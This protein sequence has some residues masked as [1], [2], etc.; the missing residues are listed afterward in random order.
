VARVHPTAV[1][2]PR[3]KLANDVEVGPYA[4]IEEGVELASGVVIGAHATLLGRTS[5]GSRTRIH[6]ASV[7]GG[8]PQ[9]RGFEGG[10][11]ALGIGEDNVIREF[12]VIH[13]GSQDGSG[14]TRIGDGN[15]IMNHVHVAHDCRIGSHCVL[16]SYSALAGHAVVEDHAVTGAFTGVHQYTRIGESAFTAANT[17]VSKGVPPFA[18]VAGD[19]ARLVGL[20]TLGLQRRGFSPDAIARLKRAYHI[21]FQSKLRLGPALE[22]VEREC[23]DSPE[24][25]RLLRFL[26][27]SERGFVR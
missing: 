21:L 22:R 18:K 26:A 8:E 15:Y 14:C 7:L 9:V 13:S 20:N 5:V 23:G 19:R 17:M 16:A 11:S 1:V 12:A 6:A 2:D 10:T 27:E 3:A 25:A 24:V 4:V